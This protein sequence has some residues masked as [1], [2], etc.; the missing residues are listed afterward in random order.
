MAFSNEAESYTSINDLGFAYHQFVVERPD[1]HRYGVGESDWTS[2]RPCACVGVLIVATAP[3]LA[4]RVEIHSWTVS[5]RYCLS[6]LD[7]ETVGHL[8]RGHYQGG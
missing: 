6:M 8:S 5:A 1:Y 3:D 7:R 2:Q 4:I